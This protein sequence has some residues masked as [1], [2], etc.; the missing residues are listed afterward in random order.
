MV[1]GGKS[2]KVIGPKAEANTQTAQVEENVAEQQ[3]PQEQQKVV[4]EGN[5]KG[6]ATPKVLASRRTP[7]QARYPC[8][9]WR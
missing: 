4:L 2:S 6:R 8:S 5:V 3:L 1:L 9:G 7:M